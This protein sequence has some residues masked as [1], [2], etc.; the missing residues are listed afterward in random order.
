MTDT[1]TERRKFRSAGPRP[2]LE[3][4]AFSVR[5]SAGKAAI[6]VTAVF[7]SPSR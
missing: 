3:F 1:Q 4:R 6:L 2:K 7:A 5:I